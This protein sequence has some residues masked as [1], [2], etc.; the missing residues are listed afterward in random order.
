MTNTA[1][2]SVSRAQGN[3][4]VPWLLLLLPAAAI[5]LG[6]R[7]GITSL[8]S[9]RWLGD[10]A[11][12]LTI[13]TLMLTPLVMMFPHVLALRWLMK[14]RRHIGMAAFYYGLAHGVLYLMAVAGFDRM[15][16]DLSRPTYALGWLTLLAFLAPAVTS[17][18]WCLRKLGPAWKDVQRIT[19][20]AAILLLAHWLM[21]SHSP[22]RVALSVLPL[23]LLELWRI[24]TI[25]KRRRERAAAK[26]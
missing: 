21:A 1:S 6:A 19:Y 13:L 11:A 7:G 15:I 18:D 23:V 17:F 3:R 2:V 20:V 25:T 9:F 12:W 5:A 4:T 14:Q 24:Y 10:V 8:G 22:E 16:A 26:G